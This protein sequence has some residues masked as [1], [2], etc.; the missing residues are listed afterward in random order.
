MISELHTD[1]DTK[2]IFFQKAYNYVKKTPRIQCQNYITG[3][4]DT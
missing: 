2:I 3:N 4:K 1:A